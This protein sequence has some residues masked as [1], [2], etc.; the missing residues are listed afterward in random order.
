[1][2]LGIPKEYFVAGMQPEVEQAVRAATREAEATA[3]E[4]SARTV[5]AVH[6]PPVDHGAGGER[7]GGIDQ[8]AFRLVAHLVISAMRQQDRIAG[9]KLPR[10]TVRQTRRAAAAD[11]EVDGS[12]PVGLDAHAERRAEITDAGDGAVQTQSI[13]DRVERVHRRMLAQR[14]LSQ[15]F[16][17]NRSCRG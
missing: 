4:G 10:L 9:A 2:K 17:T 11:D 13:E 5:A 12:D 8:V 6:L 3:E 7:R 15:C 16:R 14:T 1:M